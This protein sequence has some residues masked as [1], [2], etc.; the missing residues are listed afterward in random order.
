MSITAELS[1]HRQRLERPDEDAEAIYEAPNESENASSPPGS[2]GEKHDIRSENIQTSSFYRFGAA[3]KQPYTVKPT[4]EISDGGVSAE[5]HKSEATKVSAVA[6]VSPPLPVP[7]TSRSI[8]TFNMTYDKLFAE[9]QQELVAEYSAMRAGYMHEFQEN[10]DLNTSR[11]D[12]RISEMNLIIKAQNEYI[13]DLGKL[14]KEKE[15]L[16][17]QLCNK[18]DYADQTRRAFDRI[19]TACRKNKRLCEVFHRINAITNRQL[20][21]NGFDSFCWHRKRAFLGDVDGY[22]D[23]FRAELE[24]GQLAVERSRVDEM[25]IKAAQLEDQ[26]KME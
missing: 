5:A 13:R 1:D 25:L 3:F 2:I 10:F 15:G 22:E 17:D 26:I 23:K 4:D 14:N 16:I 12:E 19:A 6:M 9:F 21:R 24:A 18:K 8:Q 7:E 11:K 20:L